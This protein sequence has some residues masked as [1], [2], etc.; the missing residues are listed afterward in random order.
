MIIGIAVC[1]EEDYN[2]LRAII[3]DAHE[4]PTAWQDFIK[5]ADAAQQFWKEQ[6]NSVI[7][8]E[9]AA[10]A[11]LLWCTQRGAKADAAT[12]HRFAS[13]VAEGNTVD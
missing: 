7:R 4:I 12:M 3:E 13:Y 5:Q 6:G 8:V 2:A 11:F 10:P 9:I 1:R